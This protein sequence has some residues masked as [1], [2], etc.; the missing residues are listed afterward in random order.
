MNAAS[1]PHQ[2][3]AP[4]RPEG[5]WDQRTHLG[6]AAHQKNAAGLRVYT[7]STLHAYGVR[8]QLHQGKPTTCRQLGMFP[9]L[10][11]GHIPI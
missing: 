8:G 4:N 2:M 5:I 3:L 9:W 10:E 1:G 11:G 6:Q 7:S